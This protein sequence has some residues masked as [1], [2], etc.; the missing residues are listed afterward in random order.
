GVRLRPAIAFTAAYGAGLMTGL[1]HFGEPFAVAA[2]LLGG[3]LHRRAPL[4]SLLAA[5]GLLGRL[6]GE[7]AWLG[8]AD[9][10]A[11]RLAASVLHLRVQLAEPSDSSGG[12]LNVQPLD[13]GCNFPVAARWPADQPVS[14]GM[15]AEVTGRW[16]PRPAVSG[17]PS[18]TLV[19]SEV[20]PVSGQPGL[21]ALLRTRLASTSRRLYGPRAPMVD[22]LI[23]GRRSGIDRDLQDRFA[24]SGL[25]HLLSISGF[26]VGII[27]AWVFLLCRLLHVRREGALALAAGASVAYVAF[28]G[29]PP[30]A[31]RAAALAVLLAL[32]RLRQRRVETNALLS[33]TC[34]CVM[35]VDPWSVLDLGAWLSA[36]ALWGATTF[37]HWTD[38]ALGA[39]PWWRT[40]GSSVGATLATAPIT[41]AWLGAVALVGIVLNFLAIPLAAIAVPGVLASLIAFSFWPSLAE[42]LAGG[43]GLA[44]HLLELLATAG[45]AV[46]GG[47]AVGP[48]ELRSALPWVLCLA[49]GLW[50]VGK[51]NTLAEAVRRWS[52]AAV[53]ALWVGLL[54]AWA[55]GSADT[56]SG[57]ALHF[58]DVGQGD[59]AVLRTP[60]GRWVIIDAGPRG[61]HVDAGRRVVVPFLAGHG[62]GE[63][64]M[65][66]VSHAHA[67]HLGGVVSVLERHRAA[68]VLEPG[69]LVADPM[70][71]NFLDALAAEAIPWR[72]S[73]RGD[74]AVL[75]G[76]GFTILHPDPLWPGWG[77]DVNE[78]SLVLLV[79]YGAFQ[80]LFAGDAGFPAEAEMR[81]H[82]KPVDLL[83]VGHHGSRGSTGDEWL[84]SLRP[85]VAVISV[86]RNT[87]GHPSAQTLARLR[88]RRVQVWRTDR[89][90]TVTVTTDGNRM[91]VEA[92]GGATTYDVR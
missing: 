65:V 62:A 9:L 11:A 10:C 52:W 79:E 53:A 32:S 56:G 63:L 82:A 50:C 66:V 70:Y 33:A 31:T 75:D 71:Y 51:R 78:D 3:A 76:V 37:S 61:A 68:L 92:S 58:L 45:A 2:V 86:G 69:A 81:G 21:A 47:H 73:R 8:E 87:Y 54:W 44:L 25:V 60:A 30:P 74:R 43:A 57:L 55:P 91:T 6:S 48:A 49:I 4:I 67:D 29:W 59:G 12:R 90:G 41:A 17:R 22:A 14:A 35:L 84:D 27:T 18:G 20:G 38:H 24:Q 13:A 7:I 28:L 1:L 19:I 64:A 23:M 15:V 85:R 42:A 40:L 16:I 88:H 77:E 80:A 26:H 89:D 36:A 5:A 34:L 39:R 72:P 83:K 46:P